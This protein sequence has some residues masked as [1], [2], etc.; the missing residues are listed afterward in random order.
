VNNAI[1]DSD[2]LAAGGSKPMRFTVETWD[3]TYGGSV[4]Q[5]LAPTAVPVTVD[6]ERPADRWAA[7]DPSVVD[8][9]SAVLF[10]DGVRRIEARVW[11]DDAAGGEAGLSLCASYA[12][13]VVCCCAGRSHLVA[14]AVR[15][16]LVTFV[17]SATDIVTGAG[18]F[19]ALHVTPDSGTPPLVRL[20]SMLQRRMAELELVTAVGARTN[21]E[22]A[23]RGDDDLLV[24]DGP[25]RAGNSPDRT[26]GFVKTHRMTYLPAELNAVVGT[27]AAGQRTPVL[28]MGQ[29]FP[30][31]TWYLRL[32]CPPSHAWAGI[33]RVEADPHLSAA[34]AVGFA[35]LSQSVLPRF[36][37]IEYKDSRAPQNLYPIAGLERDLRRRLGDSRVLYRA[38]RAAAGSARH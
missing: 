10:V 28:L 25:L 32:P 9:P 7:V 14:N 33:V 38:L 23:C 12:A 29:Q 26:L 16:S 30:K 31:Y 27:L 20:S 37:S 34:Y 15:R 13:G 5:D 21:P 36:A 35:N 11:I 19:T 1:P 22:P 17:P 6:V 18:V 24:V 8:E 3:P 2:G 4:E